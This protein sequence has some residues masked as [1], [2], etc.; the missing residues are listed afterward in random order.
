MSNKKTY[1]VLI[2]SDRKGKTKHFT[3]SSS[4]I[5]ASIAFSA[6]LLSFTTIMAIDYV[7][8]L[9]ESRLNDNLYLENERLK[10]QFEVVESKVQSLEKGLERIKNFSTKLKLV[11]NIKDENRIFKLAI[12]PTHSDLKNPPLH[13]ISYKTKGSNNEKQ[14]KNDKDLKKQREA[15]RMKR[16]EKSKDMKEKEKD[17]S[18]HLHNEA[19]LSLP[20]LSSEKSLSPFSGN[21]NALLSI[22]IQK[23]IKEA[24]LREEDILKLWETLSDRRSLL[25]ATPS[26]N[27]VRGG[28]IT[29][30][31]GYRIDP[32]LQKSV[33]H[34]GLDIAARHGSPILAPSDGIVSFTGFGTSYGKLLEL[35]HGYGVITRY[36]H[37]SRINVKLGDRVKRGQVIAY[38][39]DTGRST[40]S[41]LHYEV[42]VNGIP[43]D[44]LRYILFEYRRHRALNEISSSL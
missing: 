10:R 20:S 44:P 26:I 35:D 16:N 5:K 31:F 7:S 8:L 32:F 38:I 18:S 12:G 41:H 24:Q 22:R 37:N 21:K 6:L 29:S 2:A 9:S 33:M 4:W 13:L 42:R 11:T 40:G 1:T 3:I 27:P 36:A 25:N 23:A 28:W 39:G 14:D 15:K 19:S 43:V 17:H 30:E 34:N